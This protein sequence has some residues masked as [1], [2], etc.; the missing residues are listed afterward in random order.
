MLRINP[1]NPT[2]VWRRGQESN[3]GHIG[4]N[5]GFSLLRHSFQCRRQQNS[6][7]KRFR[8]QSLILFLSC[9]SGVDSTFLITFDLTNQIARKA[10][11]LVWYKGNFKSA[12]TLN[13]KIQQAMPSI[14]LSK[15]GL[16][17]KPRSFQYSFLVLIM[18]PCG[19][20]R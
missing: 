8:P 15:V 19:V 20:N 14:S 9:R 5:R 16:E 17:K 13:G 10:L 3:Q 2:R 6:S 11:S 18:S 4:G 12:Q 7:A 1:T